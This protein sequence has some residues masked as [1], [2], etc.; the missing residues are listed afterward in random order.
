MEASGEHRRSNSG[1]APPILSRC[2]SACLVLLA[3]SA[4][5]LGGGL[6][7]AS[8][9]VRYAAP[10][11]T[12]SDPC[13]NRAR[14]CSV[15][16]AAAESAPRSTIKAGDVVELAPGTYHAEEDGEFGYIPPVGL[17]EGVVVRG[18]PGKPKPVILIPEE[19]DSYSAFRVPA[20]A[21]VADVEIRNRHEVNGSAIEIAGG[22]I[23]RVIA[24]STGRSNTFACGFDSG[25]VLNSACINSGGGSAIGVN[26]TATK[27]ALT[28]LIRDSTLIAT[29][30]DS[31]GMDLTF[32]AFK[33]G[34]TVSIDAVGVIVRGE[35]KD[36][37]A[38]AL[39]LNKGR[40][41][42]ISVRLRS[43][44]YATVATDAEDGGTVSV[45][46]PGTGGNTT[47]WP[48]L[49]AGNLRQLP[50]SPTVDAGAADAASGSLDV[51][52]EARTI[53]AAPDI[54]ADELRPGAS[55]V[56]PVPDVQLEFDREVEGLDPR[57]TPLRVVDLV[58]GSNELGSRFECKLDRGPYRTCSSPYR[59]RVGVGK[60][61]FQVKAV[62]P[63]GQADR[64]PA[65]IDWRVLSKRAYLR[66]IRN[67]AASHGRAA[68]DVGAARRWWR[69]PS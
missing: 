12:G 29:G 41:A 40:G 5:S 54:G 9:A 27:G 15:Y 22:T 60:H 69:A 59:K 6:S 36:V 65:V 48:L 16:T 44:D 21:E 38:N 35:E 19:G 53:G 45:T 47:A 64:T 32:S 34:L 43:S 55:T 37:I 1:E 58:F 61:R 33:R 14:P 2:L 66:W 57:W 52:G 39:A 25:I 10:G 42:D 23:N 68:P 18:E 7:V 56:D 49:A 50:G 67:L 63:A 24:R 26:N 31:V 51:D 46:K 13:A 62:D 3:A 20:A 28:G 8:A 11:G 17:A 4:F 30:P